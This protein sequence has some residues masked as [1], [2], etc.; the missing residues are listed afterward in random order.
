[1]TE[2]NVTFGPLTD[3]DLKKIEAGCPDLSDKKKSCERIDPPQ[4]GE[5]V[6]CYGNFCSYKENDPEEK[7]KARQY[8]LLWKHFQLKTIRK[9]FHI[10][11]IVEEEHWIDRPSYYTSLLGQDAYLALK[12]AIRGSC[13]CCSH[14]EEPNFLLGDR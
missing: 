11:E 5:K 2:W 1:M 6:L 12:F 9:N 3:E 8:L 10:S 14:I 4:H 13:K 7:E